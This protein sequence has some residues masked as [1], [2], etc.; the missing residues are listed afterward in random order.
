LKLIDSDLW[1]SLTGVGS[2]AMAE[3]F[4]RME[5]AER[6]IAEMKVAHPSRADAVD[7]AFGMLCPTEGLQGKAMQVYEHHVRELLTR[8]V[9]AV[10]VPEM[11]LGTKAEVLCLLLTTSLQAPLKAD[12]SAL[13]WQLGR[14]ILGAECCGTEAPTESYPEACAELLLDIRKKLRCMDRRILK[15]G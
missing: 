11:R 5:V 1:K 10:P 4:D 8:V 6:I 15:K 3:A 7:S 2:S 14:E 9:T 13:A 12:Y